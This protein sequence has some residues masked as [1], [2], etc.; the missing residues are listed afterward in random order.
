MAR[1]EVRLI[2]ECHGTRIADVT[3]ARPVSRA[4][5]DAEIGVKYWS[6]GEQRSLNDHV[7][8][9]V[10]HCRDKDCPPVQVNTDKLRGVLWQILESRLTAGTAS[11]VRLDLPQLRRAMASVPRLA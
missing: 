4:A 10:W 8:K 1:T 6:R 2:L 11:E 5:V 3:M 9:L 7:T